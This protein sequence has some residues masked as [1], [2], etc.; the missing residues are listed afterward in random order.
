M[1][2]EW[3][4]PQANS[5]VLF[6]DEGHVMKVFTRREFF[7]CD[8]EGGRSAAYDS[9]SDALA[10]HGEMVDTDAQESPLYEDIDRETV[11]NRAREFF[12]VVQR[13]YFID[14]KIT[15]AVIARVNDW[16]FD[17]AAEPNRYL[18]PRCVPILLQ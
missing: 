16:L 14:Y 7:V 6:G 3:A 17:K 8:G 13:S 10:V 11:I 1:P 12:S 4:H 2:V 15:P 9:E 5:G 18:L